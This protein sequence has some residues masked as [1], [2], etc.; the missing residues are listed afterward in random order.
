MRSDGRRAAGIGHLGGVSRMTGAEEVA[1]VAGGSA[2]HTVGCTVGHFAGD[3]A[4]DGH[5]ADTAGQVA[6]DISAVGQS[7]TRST[8][9]ERGRRTC[10][11]RVRRQ[12][13]D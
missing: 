5:T 11:R 7:L 8:V 12:C 9:C 10:L 2:G 3:T 1:D 4:A 13:W 6:V